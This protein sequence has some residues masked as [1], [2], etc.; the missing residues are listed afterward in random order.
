MIT[1]RR[2]DEQY[3]KKRSIVGSLWVLEEIRAS[4]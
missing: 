1:S 4:N 3:L 2:G